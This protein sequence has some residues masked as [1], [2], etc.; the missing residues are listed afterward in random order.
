MS[1]LLS[2]RQQFE[3]SLSPIYDREEI[4]NLFHITCEHI[5]NLKRMQLTLRM[6]EALTGEE[7]QQFNLILEQLISGK[8]IQHILGKAPFY[9]MEFFVTED[10]LIPRPET[11]ELVDLIIKDTQDKSGLRLIDIGTG[12]GCIA[13]SLAKH[14]QDARVE[15][16]DISAAAIHVAQENARQHQVN[17]D[18]KCLDILEWELTF[19]DQ[20]RF[21]IIVSNP[22]YITQEEKGAM[23]RNVLQ[24][25]PHTA[26]FVEDAAP[27]LFYDYIASFAEQHL[28]KDGVLYFEINQYLAEET[29][30][31]LLKKGFADVQILNDINAVPRMIKAKF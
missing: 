5:L 29:K 17:I 3:T 23:H 4:T 11:E 14:L 22:P 19:D 1:N 2:I 25:E 18:F 7:L 10:T 13:I 9:G 16:V 30:D 15:A 27:L 31:L 21:D 12:S 28:E 6:Q 20:Q 8:P 26:L 24:F